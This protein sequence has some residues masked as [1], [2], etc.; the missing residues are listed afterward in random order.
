MEITRQ[1]LLEADV[2]EVWLALTDEDARQEWLDDPRP[3]EVVR[4]RTGEEL[5]WR[6]DDPDRGTSSVVTLHL[7]AT[8]DGDTLLTVTETLA[9]APACSLD[10]ATVDVDAWDRRLLGLE[11]R[12]VLRA[13][14]LAG[15]HR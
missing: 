3:L 13:D 7:E 1:V 15:V 5:T 11:L 14:A 10:A 8:D 6:W 9:A 12:C 2:D 4:A